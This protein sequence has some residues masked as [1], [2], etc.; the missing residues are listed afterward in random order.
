MILHAPFTKPDAFVRIRGNLSFRNSTMTTHFNRRVVGGYIGFAFAVGM[1]ILSLLAVSMLEGYGAVG[2]CL[3]LAFFA[4]ALH[5]ILG[6]TYIQNNSNDWMMLS[7]LI[8]AVGMVAMVF[9]FGRPESDMPVGG[10]FIA[11]IIMFSPAFLCSIFLH[12]SLVLCLRRTGLFLYLSQ[13]FLGATVM[14]SVYWGDKI[15]IAS[16]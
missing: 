14:Y 13:V 4:G 12:S 9:L 3:V 10:I 2:A 11:G 5:I 15:A 8:V 7:T 6:C 16:S 1:F